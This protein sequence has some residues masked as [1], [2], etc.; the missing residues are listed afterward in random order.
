MPLLF[1]LDVRRQARYLSVFVG[2]GQS[3]GALLFVMIPVR[4]VM[5]GEHIR[6]VH[7]HIARGSKVRI[8]DQCV[9]PFG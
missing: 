7:L 8:P 4:L 5:R 1:L 6:L 2:F 9:D 3:S